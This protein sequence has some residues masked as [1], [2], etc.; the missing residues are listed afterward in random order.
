MKYSDLFSKSEI[1]PGKQVQKYHRLLAEGF[2]ESCKIE[3][4]SSLPISIVNS[5]RVLYF[6]KKEIHENVLYN[7]LP[8]L[9]IPI[10]KNFL[11]FFLSYFK[12]LNK[13]LFEKNAVVI[14]DVLNASVSFGALLACKTLNRINVGIVTDVPFYLDG[15]SNKLSNKLSNLIIKYC[16]SYIFL[17]QQMNNLLNKKN[18]PYIVVEGLVDINMRTTINLVENKGTTRICLYSGGV[19]KKY[20]LDLLVN[21]F[22]LANIQNTELH[23]YGDGDYKEELTKICQTNQSIKYFG[24][25]PN[26]HIVAEQIKATLLVNPRPSSEEFTKYSFPSKILEYMVSGTPMITTKLPGI[27]QEY[28]KY[29]Y[30]FEIE[31]EDEICKML[32]K[33]LNKTDIELHEKGLTAKEF[34]LANKNNRAQAL[35]IKSMI[36]HINQKS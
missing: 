27:P 35:K 19:Y 20:G 6:E 17:T 11:T 21:G 15:G 3:T 9:N 28:Y 5:K 18:K 29:V 8:A 34:V 10:L 25:M 36:S 24:D 23:I 33:I 26:K 2:S 14:I 4:I 30:L 22:I 32:Y 12:T 1:K 31:N 7:Y 13:C 16:S